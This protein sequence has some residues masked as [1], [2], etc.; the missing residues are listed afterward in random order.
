LVDT[1]ASMAQV[2]AQVSSGGPLVSRSQA[3]LDAWVTPEMQLQLR[4]AADVRW[5]AFDESTRPVA[6]AVGL[7]DPRELEPT[8][9]ATELYQALASADSDVSVILSDGHDNSL[10]ASRTAPDLTRAGRLFAVP[11]GSPRSADDLSIQ[12]WPDSDRLL[13]GQATTITSV[14][15]QQGFAGQPAVVELLHNGEPI[16]ERPVTLD[17]ST[18]T[19]RFE[20]KPELAP[21]ASVQAHHYTSRIRLTQSEESYTDNN[22]ED[23]FIQVS[24]GKIRVLLLEGEPYWDTRSLSRLIGSHPRF[25][26][27]AIFAFGSDR[28]SRVLGESLDPNTDPLLAIEQFDIVVLGKAVEQVVDAGFADRLRRFASDGGAVVFARGRPFDIGT[29]QGQRLLNAVEPISPVGWGQTVTGDM[30]VRLG[31]SG[32]PRGPLS[33]LQDQ[34]VLTRL[35]GLIAATRIEGRKAAS[36]VLLEQQQGEGPSMAALTTM[37]VGSGVVMAVLTDG[38]WRWELLP[39]VKGGDRDAE[40]LYGVFWIRA[41][42]WLASGGEFLPGQDIAIEVDR[43]AVEPGGSVNLR[44]STRYIES[45]DLKLEL[46]ATDSRGNTQGVGIVPGFAPG[47]FNALYTV[48]TPGVTTF[49]LSSPGR[50]D[51]IDPAQPLGTSVVAV[52][53]S[54]ER[55]DTSAQPDRLRQLTEPTGGRCLG[56]SEV[57]PVL[58]YLQSLQMARSVQDRVDYDFNTFPVFAWIAG[59]FGLEWVLRRRSGLR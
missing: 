25:D 38:L 17:G 58:E 36:L 55:R 1:S 9:E 20:I 3:V 46:T 33:G 57:Q 52:E 8:G 42:Q 51:L 19:M 41:L 6:G 50:D 11:V 54:R 31:E 2:D 40:S 22:Q 4:R 43:L 29:P 56:L 49:R 16:E 44:I 18:M 34:A 30:R 5:L 45:K 28:K 7:A 39:G 59:C 37:R 26:L 27:T 47:S 48:T 12:A 24:R 32:D 13:E 35:P 14:I 15:E 21:G 23:L 53:R 10:S